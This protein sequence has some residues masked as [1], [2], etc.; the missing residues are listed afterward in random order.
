VTENADKVMA[1]NGSGDFGKGVSTPEETLKP[2]GSDYDVSY[3]VYNDNRNLNDFVIGKTVVG[4]GADEEDGFTFEVR[5]SNIPKTRQHYKT[6]SAEI[7]EWKGGKKI[8][9]TFPAEDT[10]SD[11]YA[12]QF[13]LKSGWSAAFTDIPDKVSYQITEKGNDYIASYK[14]SGKNEMTNES[15]AEVS[16]ANENA[17]ADL[18]LSR[19][20]PEGMSSKMEYSFVNKKEDVPIYN[21]LKISKTV[22]DGADG[23]FDFTASFTGLENFTINAGFTYKGEIEDFNISGNLINAALLYTNDPLSI[24]AD[25]VFAVG[26]DEDEAN[27]LYTAANV[28]YQITEP[29]SVNLYGYF[30]TD[31]D[32]DDS[33]CV[34]VNP[35]V[36]YQLTEHNTI[37]GGVF[38]NVMKSLKSISFPIYWKYAL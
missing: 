31:F 29:L 20:I 12:V 17:Y 1:K 11:S 23:E 19:E 3:D 6:I 32:N 25:V 13:E 15:L 36:D 26:G 21:N 28:T 18:G 7:Y 34:G 33:W 27:E 2:A 22:T 4:T 30:T 10:G 14:G 38:V 8:I 16:D 9:E 37:G 5:F 24:F 35:S